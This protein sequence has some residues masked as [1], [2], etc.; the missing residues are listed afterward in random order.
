M[1]RDGHGAQK[2]QADGGDLIA[3]DAEGTALSD[4]EMADLNAHSG[5]G[6]RQEPGA[7]PDDDEVFGHI[8]GGEA[9]GSNKPTET[10][11]D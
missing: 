2:Q 5:R 6:A 1:T 7:D 10:N 8:Q 3:E 11:P 9:G 4:Q